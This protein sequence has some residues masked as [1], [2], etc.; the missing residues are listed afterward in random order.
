MVI[1]VV[2]LAGTVLLTYKGIFIPEVGAGIIVTILGL[3]RFKPLR[4]QGG[5]LA[6]TLIAAATLL[7]G[8]AKF[9]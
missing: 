6:A 7:A 8:K 1:D 3:M 4:D 2:G 9:L 5:P